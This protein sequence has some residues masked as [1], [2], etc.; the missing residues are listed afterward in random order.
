[1][2]GTLTGVFQWYV[3]GTQGPYL[4]GLSMISIQRSPAKVCWWVVFNGTILMTTDT[5]WE[6]EEA[7]SVFQRK[8]G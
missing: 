6:A 2:N 4:W 1:M 8:V 5:K 3:M 7:A